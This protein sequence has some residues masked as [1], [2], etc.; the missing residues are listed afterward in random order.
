[1][2]TRLIFGSGSPDRRRVSV[3]FTFVF[4]LRSTELL[5]I[6]GNYT[7]KYVVWFMSGRSNREIYK[8]G[9]RLSDVDESVIL[10]RGRDKI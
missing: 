6:S 4:I 2:G 7:L 9:K 3:S 8:K 5:I 10:E 1:M